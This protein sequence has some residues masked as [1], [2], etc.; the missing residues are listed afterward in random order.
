MGKPSLQSKIRGIDHSTIESWVRELASQ[1][2]ITKLR[3]TGSHELDDKWFT[4]YMAE[5]HGTLGCIAEAGGKDMEDIRDLYTKGLP[6]K[7]LLNLM[8]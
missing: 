2:K 5:I 1:D 8:D 3:G 4:T 7:L 6:T